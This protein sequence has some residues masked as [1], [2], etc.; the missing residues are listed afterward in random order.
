MEKGYSL[1]P[2]KAES[3]SEPPVFYMPTLC[4]LKQGEAPQMDR[5][6]LLYT[7]I[8]SKHSHSATRK[9]SYLL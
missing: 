9:I 5:W 2:H 1:L 4:I 8:D 6:V 3:W 7:N